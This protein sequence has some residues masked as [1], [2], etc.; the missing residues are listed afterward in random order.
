MQKEPPKICIADLQRVK[1]DLGLETWEWPRLPT[2]QC[3]PGNLVI[4]KEAKSSSGQD[5]TFRSLCGLGMQKIRVAARVLSSEETI[6]RSQEGMTVTP[7]GIGSEHSYITR[8]HGDNNNDMGGNGTTTSTDG[9]GAAELDE[10]RFE[11]LLYPLSRGPGG[12][13]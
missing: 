12:P 3:K 1:R 9:S 6:R 5:H 7:D 10:Y 2:C 13:A 8:C 11:A 4:L